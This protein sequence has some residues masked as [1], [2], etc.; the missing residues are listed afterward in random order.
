MST[1]R[2][3]QSRQLYDKTMNRTVFVKI[4]RENIDNASAY[5]NQPGE[6]K[7]WVFGDEYK[8]DPPL[9]EATIV[10]ENNNG[11]LTI[12]GVHEM[13]NGGT[14]SRKVKRSKQSKKRY[15]TRRR[16]SSKRQSR[17]MNKRRK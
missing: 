13:Y 9:N 16:R 11:I 5:D 2:V 4:T 1:L 10:F 12:D 15:T 7:T 14:R 3:E 17:K 8:E 6:S